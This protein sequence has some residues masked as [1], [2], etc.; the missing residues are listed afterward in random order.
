M[1]YDNEIITENTVS[2]DQVAI[3]SLA[4]KMQVSLNTLPVNSYIGD[5]D[6]RYIAVNRSQANA[7]ARAGL[8]FDHF[9]SQTPYDIP[10]II[11]NVQPTMPEVDVTPI[12]HDIHANN[13]MVMDQAKKRVFIELWATSTTDVQIT[14]SVKDPVFHDDTV[15]GYIGRSLDIRREKIQKI[16]TGAV[17]SQHLSW[18]GQ[19]IVHN[20]EAIELGENQCR[21][22]CFFVTGNKK[23]L[24]FNPS[25]AKLIIE[26]LK[27]QLGITSQIAFVRTLLSGSLLKNVIH[28]LKNENL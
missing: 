26:T 6:N 15:I 2:K 5:R 3:R 7:I 24:N 14:Y 12:W 9:D 4:K 28:I 10:K 18:V 13:A 17:D 25:Q 20:G 21:A 1:C 11:A 22:L 8:Q 23:L 19:H 27:Q 16:L